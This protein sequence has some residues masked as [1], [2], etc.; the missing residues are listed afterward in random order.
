MN[1]LLFFFF[2]TDA[3]SILVWV[4]PI[5]ALIV[6]VLIGFLVYRLIVKNRIGSARVSA[7]TIVDEAQSEA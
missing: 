5:I 7:K 2:A 6:G 4:L 3:I 1:T